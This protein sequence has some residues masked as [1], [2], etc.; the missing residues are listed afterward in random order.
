MIVV[1][2]E[3]LAV[4]DVERLVGEWLVARM[5]VKAVSVVVSLELQIRGR[6]R[7]FLYGQIAATALWQVHVL[8]AFIA[9]HPSPVLHSDPPLILNG[10]GTPHARQC[11][12]AVLI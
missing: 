2:A 3:R 12:L 5:T 1:V 9:Q 11:L 7:L 8:P 10:L 6:H 4:K